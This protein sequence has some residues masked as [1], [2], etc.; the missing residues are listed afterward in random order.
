[1]ADRLA[2]VPAMQATSPSFSV[3]QAEASRED[4]VVTLA[5][6][7]QQLARLTTS[8]DLISAEVAE[9]KRSTPY[10]GNRRARGGSRSET[11]ASRRSRMYRGLNA[12]GLCWYHLVW[13]ANANKCSEGCRQAG[14]GRAGR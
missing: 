4:D 14:N 10:A 3:T 7:H 9:L 6:L 5:S 1:M 13:G 8:N 2:S 11:V 12:D